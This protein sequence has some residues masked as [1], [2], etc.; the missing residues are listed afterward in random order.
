VLVAQ[1]VGARQLVEGGKA[2]VKALVGGVEGQVGGRAQQAGAL[3]GGV[4]RLC[5]REGG[6]VA[7]C[8]RGREGRMT[9]LRG[10]VGEEGCRAAAHP[11]SPPTPRTAAHTPHLQAQHHVHGALEGIA[12]HLK[13][14]QLQARCSLLPG[15]C[16]LL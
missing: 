7:D 3:Q 6:R 8:L 15:G 5:G 1:G 9:A 16:G 11:I 4:R 2:L 14:E 13:V 10:G 12:Q